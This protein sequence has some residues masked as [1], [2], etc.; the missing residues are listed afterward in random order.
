MQSDTHS[1]CT[2][3][4]LGTGR[5]S[6]GQTP[7]LLMGQPLVPTF[8]PE[9]CFS[10]TAREISL[11]FFPPSNKGCAKRPKKAIFITQSE[12]QPKG[13]FPP[14]QCLAGAKA[15]APGAAPSEGPSQGWSWH[16]RAGDTL[17]VTAAAVARP[18][19]DALALAG[20]SCQVGAIPTGKTWR[21]ATP[22]CGWG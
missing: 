12:I 13:C 8:K 14:T 15:T 11:H 20:L 21:K 19:G 1:P 9:D 22:E 10:S 2:G 4:V 17:F 5:G 18:A 16:S 3:L 6:P 7:P